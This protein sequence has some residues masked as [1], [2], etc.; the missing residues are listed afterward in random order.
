MELAATFQKLECCLAH[1]SLV[2]AQFVEG[3]MSGTYVVAGIFAIIQT[4][5]LTVEDLKRNIPALHSSA[6]IAKHGWWP[7]GI[8]GIFLFPFYLGTHF[9][10]D[11]IDWVQ[12]RQAYRWAIWHEPVLYDINR[13]AV[14][15][16]S[17]YGI[18][19]SAFLALVFGL[20]KRALLSIAKKLG[21]PHPDFIN[22]QHVSSCGSDQ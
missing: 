15:M 11:V 1:D 18:F 4:D 10:P 8:S 14:W 21:Q 19:G 20:R 16:R 9:E 3:W 2:D 12:R 7:R 6:K 22:D 17:D 5:R 13:N